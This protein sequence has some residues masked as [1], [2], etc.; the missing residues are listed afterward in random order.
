M[1]AGRSLR[2]PPGGGG[3][4]QPPTHPHQNICVREN[5][6][7]IKG[8]GNLRPILATQ[9]FFLSDPPPRGHGPLGCGLAEG[10]QG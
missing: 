5:M 2:T 6:K 8:A 3:A 1:R 7:S 9:T 10:L 4:G